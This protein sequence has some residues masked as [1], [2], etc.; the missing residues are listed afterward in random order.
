[1]DFAVLESKLKY[2]HTYK[3]L[4]PE[5]V[6]ENYEAAFRVEYTH[7]STAI[8]GNTLSLMETKLLLEDAISPGGK[9]LR[10]IFEVV[11]HNKAF[12]FASRCVAE[13]KALDKR[14]VKDIHA[15]LM[16]N[17]MQ[18]GIYR[19]VNV[20]ISGARHKPPP[21]GEAYRQMECF[22]ADMDLRRQSM[23]PLEFA[24]WTHAEFVKIHPFVDGN[25][26]AS[27]LIMN[28]QLA[29]AGYL[30]VSV[31]LEGRLEYFAALEAYACESDL[32]PFSVLVAGLEDARLSQYITAIQQ[33]LR[34]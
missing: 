33:L 21:P 28:Y 20:Y 13:G 29:A 11:N 25:G 34:T 6:K 9:K 23:H 32:K 12:G 15:I 7:N 30:P 3:H 18:G 16:E 4:I 19:D 5:A 1:M 10:E 22:F 27:R 8:E 31:P 17:I 26:R 14:I 2:F 24:A